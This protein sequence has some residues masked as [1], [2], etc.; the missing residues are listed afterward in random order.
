MQLHHISRF[1][2]ATYPLTLQESYDNAGLIYGRPETEITGV[3]I[4][5][6]VTEAVVA[7]ALATNCNLIIAHHPII[8]TG[9]KKLHHAKHISVVGNGDGRHSGFL[10]F[11]N[12]IRNSGESV[13]QTVFGMKM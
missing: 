2:E 13:Q 11:F 4:S 12:K 3:L 8:F 1:L 7:E 5:L 9:I 6:D 10:R